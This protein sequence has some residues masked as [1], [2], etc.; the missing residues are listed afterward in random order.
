MYR[1]RP[2][3][4]AGA[5]VW[6]RTATAAVFRVVPD[7]CMDLIWCDGALMVAGPDT[8]A[9]L[10]R[11]AP[12]TEYTGLRFAPGM[13]PAALGVPASEL[14]DR[15][16]PLDELWPV[17]EVRQLAE[18]TA[19]ARARGSVLEGAA[20]A[21]L[22]AADPPS[23]TVAAIVRALRAGKSVAVVAE[24]AGITP[25]QLRRRAHDAFGYGPKTLARV[26]RMNRALALAQAGVPWA[27]TAVRSGYA[28]QPHLTREVKALTGIAPG[29]LTG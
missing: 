17:P 3:R 11:A 1:E 14:R 20:E 16:V 2:A 4:L 24:E 26:L 18:R 10:V 13:G 5:V 19:A 15:R 29:A 12:G 27:E 21:R 22:R 28:D 9:H 23:P 8:R 25:R 7:G 6:G